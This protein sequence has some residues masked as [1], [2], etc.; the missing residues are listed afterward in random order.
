MHP[1]ARKLFTEVF[2]TDPQDESFRPAPWLKSLDELVVYDDEKETF[3][4]DL[5]PLNE[6]LRQSF[7]ET[8]NH[9]LA[10]KTGEEDTQYVQADESGTLATI[11]R[12]TAESLKEKF[13]NGEQQA[14]CKYVMERYHGAYVDAELPRLA[15]Q[16]FNLDVGSDEE[17]QNRWG[18]TQL[19]FAPITRGK[20]KDLALFFT[21]I[22]Y[23]LSPVS[24]YEWLAY[25]LEK[26]MARAAE[27]LNGSQFV[28][29]GREQYFRIIFGENGETLPVLRIPAGEKR[30]DQY[31]LALDMGMAKQM[32]DAGLCVDLSADVD[33]H[34]THAFD[35]GRSG[36]EQR[37]AAAKAFLSATGLS[38]L[39]N[40]Q[41]RPEINYKGKTI[42]TFSG[43]DNVLMGYN[44]RTGEAVNMD[45]HE[46]VDE[47]KIEMN[48]GMGFKCLDKGEVESL[49]ADI[50]HEF[51]RQMG[52]EM[53]PVT[54]SKY[55][56]PEIPY[57]LIDGLLRQK[58]TIDLVPVFQKYAAVQ[59]DR[60]DRAQ[61]V[62]QSLTDSS[63]YRGW[64]MPLDFPEVFYKDDRFRDEKISLTFEGYT[65]PIE[66]GV[67]V[68]SIF[69][70]D[71]ARLEKILE[72]AHLKDE[73][74]V[75]ANA[76]TYHDGTRHRF[77][78]EM[79]I[80]SLE[81]AEDLAARLAVV[82]AEF[83]P[84][85]T[86]IIAKAKSESVLGH[87]IFGYPADN[88]PE[89][90]YARKICYGASVVAIERHKQGIPDDAGEDAKM[91][92]TGYRAAMTNM[93]SYVGYLAQ[94]KKSD[95]ETVRG[96]ATEALAVLK[97]LSPVFATLEQRGETSAA[98]ASKLEKPPE[99]SL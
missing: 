16:A 30:P 83:A 50:N 80:D 69:A 46:P 58:K 29:P 55:G 37:E 71:A 7:I 38:A 74:Q 98:P 64:R 22:G 72:A 42:A 18:Y 28:D 75:E 53:A 25:D 15:K 34:M 31:Y 61:N 66:K 78:L 82:K 51:S 49:A 26:T 56:T 81:Q 9:A 88:S 35:H 57:N 43:N 44:T 3:F 13:P 11:T 93:Q 20:T 2:D 21:N 90:L 65:P 10:R 79:K 77:E 84:A 32:A 45:T 86:D 41:W 19:Q 91:D 63:G 67:K 36:L 48:V 27:F 40:G 8:L 4:F 59:H 97:D 73:I 89:Q 62:I 92:A 68:E 94:A 95:D 76:Y 1:A 12:T 33:S 99:L 14:S 96:I 52:N 47:T 6:D 17:R 54:M 85:I 24:S 70:E 23:D 39:A 60:I 5:L 87:T